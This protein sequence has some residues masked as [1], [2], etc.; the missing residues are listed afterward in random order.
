L[1]GYGTTRLF[2]ATH[3]ERPQ[4][5][6]VD[7]IALWMLSRSTAV[8][9]GLIG[10]AD[11]GYR[12]RA[13]ARALHGVRQRLPIGNKSQIVT[14]SNEEKYYFATER[15]R[16]GYDKYRHDFAQLIWIASP[17]ELR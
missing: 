3:A 6:A 9:A 5:N 4:S 1:R 16:S 13:L 11:G 15:G 14:A 12:S 8:I 2:R 17:V 7:T 10:S